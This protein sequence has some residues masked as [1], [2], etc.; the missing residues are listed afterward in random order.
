MNEPTRLRD[1]EGA[2]RQ[3]MAGSVMHV[4]SASRRRAVAF[5][6]AAAT[7]GAS[8]TAV[9]ASAT[10]VVKSFVL[11]VAIGAA[12]GGAMSLLA[13]ETFARFDTKATSDAQ[14]VPQSSHVR[15]TPQ[16]APQAPAVVA[17][18]APPEVPPPVAA[19]KDASGVGKSLAR[20]DGATRSRDALQAPAAARPEPSLFE[21]QRII[22]SA[23]AAVA[24]GDARTA[25]SV[26]DHYERAYA[27]K[28]FWPEAL[29][30][31]VEALRNSGQLAAARVLAADFA[32]KYP[33]HPLLQRVRSAVA[34]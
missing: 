12:G 14:P 10:S 18:E 31:R 17:V 6:S 26:L 24:R 8:A 16:L 33:H 2:A 25:F 23:R 1:G 30:L 9:A 21:E 32:Q 22:E 7:M 27:S 4:P 20:E 28:Q 19:A 13:S 5:T 15:V 29:A 34:R 11:C 3:L